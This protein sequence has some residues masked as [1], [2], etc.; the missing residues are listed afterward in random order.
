MITIFI[1]NRKIFNESID[2][3]LS[4]LYIALYKP[5]SFFI[6]LMR[7]AAIISRSETQPILFAGVEIS[8]SFKS[9]RML[10]F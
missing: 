1:K 9:R 6:V 3:G 7:A 8:E 10:W 4:Y 2:V 5:Y